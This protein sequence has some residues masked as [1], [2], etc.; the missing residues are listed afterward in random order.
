MTG[1]T[2]GLAIACVQLG[3]RAGSSGPVAVATSQFATVGVILSV[4]FEK[5]TL[6]RL[7]WI[8]LVCAG[9]GV[10]LLAAG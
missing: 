2:A 4:I 3:Y 6:R 7:Q 8:G 10:A 1:V 9:V 5:E